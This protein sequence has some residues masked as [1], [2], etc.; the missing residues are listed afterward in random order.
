MYCGVVAAR[1]TGDAAHPPPLRCALFR[2][3]IWTRAAATDTVAEPVSGRSTQ[4]EIDDGLDRPC[5]SASRRRAPGER[6]Q[7]S[8]RA[9]QPLQERVLANR[10][11]AQASV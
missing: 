3:E 11:P 1:E 6:L 9:A 4:G 7:S 5:R 8:G 2:H 10:R